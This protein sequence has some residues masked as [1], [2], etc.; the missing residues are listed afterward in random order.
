VT[1]YGLIAGLHLSEMQTLQPGFVCD[2]YILRQ[3]Y[4]DQQH[5]LKRQGEKEEA[6]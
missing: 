6:D 2:M 3:K 1:S 5:G 4:D